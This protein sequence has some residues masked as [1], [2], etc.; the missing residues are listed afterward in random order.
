M[1]NDKEITKQVEE[2]D[3]Q[4]RVKSFN[5]ELL[6]LLKKYQLSLGATAFLTQDGRITAIPQVF[7]DNKK[8]ESE[9]VSADTGNDK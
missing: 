2:S 1:I 6:S 8:A 3:F 7:P 9:I 4:N 5:A